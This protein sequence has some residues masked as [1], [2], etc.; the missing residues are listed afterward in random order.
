MAA[1]AL[2]AVIRW[3]GFRIVSSSLVFVALAGARVVVVLVRVR[4]AGG[5]MVGSDI[6]ELSTRFFLHITDNAARNNPDEKHK[7]LP[8]IY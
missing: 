6:P 8:L 7:Q 3:A 5:V 4:L 1:T 2:A